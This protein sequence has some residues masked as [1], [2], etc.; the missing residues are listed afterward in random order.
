MLTGSPKMHFL[1][2]FSVAAIAAAAF[3][4]SPSHAQWNGYAGDPQHTAISA[5]AASPLTTIRWSTP[6]DEAPP[7]GTI[8]I[9]YGSPVITAANTVVV[10]VRAAGGAYCIDAHAGADGSLLW[11]TMTDY[12]ITPTTGGWV[13]SFSPTLTPGGSLYYQ[14]IGGTVWRI[15]DP[16]SSAI[17]PVQISFLP[18]YTANKAAYDT[19]VFI[20]TP[21]TSDAAGNIYFGYEVSGS[22]PGALT[23]GIARIAPDGTAT[24]TSANAASGIAGAL[25]LR[26]GTNSAPALSLDG[27]TLYVAIHG[28]GDYLAAID[29]ATLAPQHHTA[30]GGIIADVSTASPTIGPDGHVYFGVLYGY[31][32]RGILQ[33]FTADLSQTLTSGSFGWDD[34]P[35]IVPA[36]MVPSY[37]G[38]S[39]YLLM[40]KYNDYKDIGGT[41]VNK[42]AILDPNDTQFD[43]LAGQNVMRE[44]LTIAGVTPDPV[45]PYVREWCINTAA[46]DPATGS[47]LVNSEDGTLYRWNL[48]TNTFAESIELQALGTLEAYTPTVIGPDGTVYAINKATLF[49]VGVPEPTSA[50][51]FAIG[52]AVIPALRRRALCVA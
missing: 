12:V 49:A 36:S 23:S 34:T 32:F 44:V 24:T 35:S 46:V 51:L 17:S 48:A 47:I 9:H 26:M 14:G 18:D 16:N 25:N 50:L 52:L 4:A 39:S 13:P 30:L 3:F 43:P 37:H 2:V 27:S 41:G 8:Y 6:V 10:P 22:A 11:E 40:V 21:I 28:N 19:T 42:L 20:S 31:H 15:A 1:R 38:T 7:A 5:V 45:F 29:A 33:H